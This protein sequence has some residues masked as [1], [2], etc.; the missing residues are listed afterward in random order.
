MVNECKIANQSYKKGK[1]QTNFNSSI[2]Y[3]PLPYSYFIHPLHTII[4]VNI[5]YNQNYITK[6]FEF[7]TKKNRL[8]QPDHAQHITLCKF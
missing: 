8:R 7:L 5:A 2:L 3:F 6:C 1:A 4:K